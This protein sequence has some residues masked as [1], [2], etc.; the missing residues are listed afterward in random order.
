MRTATYAVLT[1]GTIMLLTGC[2]HKLLDDG[3]E[4]KVNV[5]V[6]YDWKEAPL[7]MPEGMSSWFYDTENGEARRF[8]FVGGKGGNITLPPGQWHVLTYN[9]DVPG[10]IITNTHSFGE[11]FVTTR[12]G[13]PLEG[14]LGNGAPLPPRAEGTDGERVAITPDMMY[15]YTMPDHTVEIR[16]G[17]REHVV[18][19]VPHEMM[20]RYS[21]EIRN[22]EN[23]NHVVDMCAT[24]SGMS[25][26]MSVHGETLHTELVT[27]PLSAEKGDATTITG[28]FFVF[29]H[30]ES[31]SAPHR[32]VL[33][34]WMD[35]GRKLVYG[36]K[37]EDKWDVSDQIDYAP[38]PKR[39]HIVIDGLDIPTPFEGSL[40]NPGADDWTTEDY[41]FEI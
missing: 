36:T 37:G 38:D 11:H 34:V 1:A 9:N 31:N 19:L 35:D 41:E 28:E 40:F 22:V 32:M 33:Y 6:A 21:Y 2:R 18:T 10:C 20:C 12:E 29:G 16:K 7:A 3:I 23:L 25:G 30:H 14:S 15:G 8:D 4:L 5:R 26:G 17:E 39:V 27:H 24:L 13:N